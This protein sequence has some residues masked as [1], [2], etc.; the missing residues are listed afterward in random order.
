MDMKLISDR[1]I[2]ELEKSEAK[3]T[4]K[5]WYTQVSNPVTFICSEGGHLAYSA[6]DFHW[7]AVLAAKA[8]NSI[9]PLLARLHSAEKA[10]EF[11]ADRKPF[12]E[13]QNLNDPRFKDSLDRGKRARSHFA[14]V[15][16]E[17]G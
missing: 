14:K 16:G 3:A 4:G 8:R 7:D 2:E 6:F 12:V 10:L 9:L 11:Y 5:H 13:I 15:E 17:K 1:E